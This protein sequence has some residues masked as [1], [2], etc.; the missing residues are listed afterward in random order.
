[1][2]T[3]SAKTD[4]HNLI[5]SD[6]DYPAA[7]ANVIA[8]SLLNSHFRVSRSFLSARLLLLIC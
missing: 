1:M 4:P 8:Y 7:T 3:S 6:Y 5:S 2:G